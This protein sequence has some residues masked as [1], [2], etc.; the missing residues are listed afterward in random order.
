[1]LQIAANWL[2]QEANEIAEAKEA[3]LA[4][5]CPAPDLSGDQTALMVNGK[6]R[7][8]S[9]HGFVLFFRVAAF[10]VFN[11]HRSFARSYTW[12]WIRSTR[13]A[14]TLRPKWRSRPRR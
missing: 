4:E 2:E 5:R 14:T 9:T 8:T 6:Q 7:R 10:R 1:M 12:L 11:P 13:T 3:Y